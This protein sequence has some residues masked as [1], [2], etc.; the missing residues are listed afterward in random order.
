[1][2]RLPAWTVSRAPRSL[3]GQ[4]QLAIALAL[5]VAQGLSA[6]LIWREQNERRVQ[7]T[8]NEA[9][10]RLIGQPPARIGE[11]QHDGGRRQPDDRDH[12]HQLDKGETFLHVP[13]LL[14]LGFHNLLSL[15]HAFYS[16]LQKFGV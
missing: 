3:Q 8:V 15:S 5:L 13:I 2:L 16:G 12:D 6:A 14:V 11:R 9:A 7:L 4:M 10:F 1:M